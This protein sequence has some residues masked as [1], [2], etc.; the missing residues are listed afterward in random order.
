MKEYKIRQMRGEET[1]EMRG[2]ETEEM[3]QEEMCVRERERE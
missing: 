1:E 2:D 3:R